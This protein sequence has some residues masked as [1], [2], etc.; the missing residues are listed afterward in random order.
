MTG[1]TATD[2][3]E[4]A[5]AVSRADISVVRGD[6]HLCTDVTVGDRSISVGHDP[7]AC[8]IARTI[9]RTADA[10]ASN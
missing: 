6:Q 2:V 5:R 8:H 9:K 4:F 1:C 7:D 3:R 10:V